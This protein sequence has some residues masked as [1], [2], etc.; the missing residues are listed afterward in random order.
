VLR[1]A[2]RFWLRDGA[3]SFVMILTD[4]HAE[5]PSHAGR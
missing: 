3:N 2:K 1:F 4:T 5:Q